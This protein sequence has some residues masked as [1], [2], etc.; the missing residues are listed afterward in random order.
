MPW[1]NGNV[2]DSDKQ[3]SYYSYESN[4]QET[5]PNPI[6]Y[7]PKDENGNE[8]IGKKY[9]IQKWLSNSETDVIVD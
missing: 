5:S 4:E 7:I 3:I 9:P 8:L 6:T 1:G 2:R